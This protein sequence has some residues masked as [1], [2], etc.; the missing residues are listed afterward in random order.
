MELNLRNFVNAGIGIV[1]VTQNKIE[2]NK[3]SFLKAYED[4]VAKGAAD[5]TESSMR[6]RDLTSKLE[7]GVKDTSSTI[8]KNFAELKSI[9]SA[10]RN[11]SPDKGEVNKRQTKVLV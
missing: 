5:K 1:K 2:E 9:I 8:K 10:P 4:L 11:P 6:V 7:A 3:K